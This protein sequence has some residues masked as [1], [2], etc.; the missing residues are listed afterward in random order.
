MVETCILGKT[1]LFVV[2]ANSMRRVGSIAPPRV[3]VGGISISE[4]PVQLPGIATAAE[5]I[6]HVQ[7]LRKESLHFGVTCPHGILQAT[8]QCPVL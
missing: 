7:Q 2:R 6:R 1:L 5:A 8:R 3:E 4:L